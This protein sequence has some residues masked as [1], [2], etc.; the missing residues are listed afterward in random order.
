MRTKKRQL[1]RIHTLIKNWAVPVG[2]GLLF[3]F[4]LKCVF[5]VGYVPTD[6]MEP[7]IHEGSLI[8]GIRIFSVLDRGDIVVFEHEGRLLVKRIAA[9][10]GDAV[11]DEQKIMFVP[12]GQYFVLGDNSTASFDSRCW[13]Q[14]F[15]SREKIIARILL[16]R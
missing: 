15:I 16:P 1:I 7:A 12:A 13:D 8:I 4:L 6:S 14:P 5:F 10:P 3:L 11:K 9:T 2:C